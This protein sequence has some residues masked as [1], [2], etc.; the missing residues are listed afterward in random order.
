M[1]QDEVDRNQ[2][3]VMNMHSFLIQW[4]TLA[5]WSLQFWFWDPWN[6]K[7]KG[8]CCFAPVSAIEK[9]ELNRC[10]HGWS[11]FLISWTASSYM[12]NAWLNTLYDLLFFPAWKEKGLNCCS[13][14]WTATLQKWVFYLAS[15]AWQV[16]GGEGRKTQRPLFVDH[17]ISILLCRLLR[18]QWLKEQL[19]FSAQSFR[20]WKNI[21][22]VKREEEG[23][24]MER[25]RGKRTW[26]KSTWRYQPWENL[27]GCNKE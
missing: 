5:K 22:E 14:C 24:N 25:Q 8:R 13:L 17:F 2:R 4:T 27:R 10:L 1:P 15:S 26:F 6:T 16:K 21:W 3:L 7:W 20:S 12:S 23:G 9:E 19:R 11:I 18:S